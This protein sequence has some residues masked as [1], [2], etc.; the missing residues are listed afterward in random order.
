MLSVSRL[1]SAPARPF[2]LGCTHLQ[3]AAVLSVLAD[4]GGSRMTLTLPMPTVPAELFQTKFYRYLSLTLYV[5]LGTL[6]THAG[7]PGYSHGVLWV[8]TRGALGTPIGYSGYSRRVAWVLPSG[9]LGTPIGLTAGSPSRCSTF[10]EV[11]NRVV[12]G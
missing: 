4:V 11:G 8:L 7:C 10:R 12:Y 1:A 2:P 3:K 5:P 6:G 9:T